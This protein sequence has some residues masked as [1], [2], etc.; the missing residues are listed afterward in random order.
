[1]LYLTAIDADF[2]LPTTGHIS[3]NMFTGPSLRNH[4]IS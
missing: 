3:L 4:R 2:G 1:V